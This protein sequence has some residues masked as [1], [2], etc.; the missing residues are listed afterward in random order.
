MW[1]NWGTEESGESAEVILPLYI[2]PTAFKLVFTYLAWINLEM[3]EKVWIHSSLLALP[4]PHL[5]EIAW[6]M[7]I[8]CLLYLP[9]ALYLSVWEWGMYLSTG[10][11]GRI[12]WGRTELE[13]WGSKQVYGIT[14]PVSQPW[15]CSHEV[16]ALGCCPGGSPGGEVVP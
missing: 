10:L 16:Q 11:H 3:R 12:S 2:Q 7:Q 5:D 1:G 14:G 8:V 9:V 4:S 13:S 15:C 6:V